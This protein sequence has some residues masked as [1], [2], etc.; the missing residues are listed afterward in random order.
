MGFAGKL[1][2]SAGHIWPYVAHTCCKTCSKSFFGFLIQ[3]EF[4]IYFFLFS[5]LRSRIDCQRQNRNVRSIRYCSSWKI[6]KE[7]ENSSERIEPWLEREVLLVSILSL[8]S[9][10][11]FRLMLSLLFWLKVITLSGFYCIL[12]LG[13]RI[14]LDAYLDLVH[15]RIFFCWNKYFFVWLI[16][17][18]IC[19]E[20]NKDFWNLTK[21]FLT[22]Y[23]KQYIFYIFEFILNKVFWQF[24]LEQCYLEVNHPSLVFLFCQVKMFV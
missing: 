22:I 9:F 1:E 5:H 17:E 23:D 19:G 14:A 7:N 2:A 24:F 8:S 21:L 13:L 4:T 11:F 18:P 10:S 3:T 20:L 16:L 6:T 15:L 12:S